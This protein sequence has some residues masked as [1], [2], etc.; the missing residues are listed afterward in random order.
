MTT[1]AIV[2]ASGLA[3]ISLQ[4]VLLPVL[5]RYVVD[6]PN[7]RSSH[8]S[9]TA[10]GGGIAVVGG[11]W[12]GVIA[13]WL[14]GLPIPWAVVAVALGLS[15]LLGLADDIRSVGALTRLAIQLALG[16]ALALW[17]FRSGAPELTGLELGPLIL[18]AALWLA[19]FTNAYNFMDGIN[20]I[21]AFT[22][23]VAGTWY[24]YVGWEWQV[25]QLG[26]LGLAVAGAGAGFLPWNLP[27]ARVFLGDVG[28]YAIGMSLAGLALWAA[29]AGV[30]L[31]SAAAPLL[32]YVVD[33]GWTLTRRIATGRPWRQAHRDHVYQRLVDGGW[34]HTQS[35]ML[36]AFAALACCAVSMVA[37]SVDVAVGL[38]LLVIG[39]VCYLLLP[40]AIHGPQT[41]LPPPVVPSVQPDG[42]VLSPRSVHGMMPASGSE[43][44]RHSR[45]AQPG[46]REL[47]RQ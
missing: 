32:V 36:S 22:A 27:R 35:S 45:S 11:V 8:R 7:G 46:S 30:P 19:G 18:L 13:G 24:V 40:Q 17:V 38:L 1:A 23:V 47:T 12:L 28:A 39:A 16:L 2:L 15:A 4:G 42:V 44:G 21:S 34:S 3:C 10:R 26:V 5:R 25:E 29:V 37:N 33:T 20:G 14:V 41:S 9:P 6:V 43:P 31:W